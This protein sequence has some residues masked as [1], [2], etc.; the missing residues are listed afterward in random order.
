M[1]DG[2]CHCGS[3]RWTLLE[4]PE[5]VTACNRTACRRYCV[6][7]AYGYEDETIEVAGETTPYTRGNS[8]S[9]NFCAR[10]G[11]V[12][13]WRPLQPNAGRRK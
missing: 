2:S 4:M 12:T 1:I 8:L 9:F 5:S 11:G 3:A 10:C 13:H 7:W 6:L